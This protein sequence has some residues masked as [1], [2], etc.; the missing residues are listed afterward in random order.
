M[1]RGLTLGGCHLVTVIGIIRGCPSSNIEALAEA[2][3]SAGVRALEVTLDSPEPFKSIRALASA[4]PDI[5]VGA[6]TVRDLDQVES[7]AK[8]GARFIVSPILDP[9]LVAHAVT[10]GMTTIPGAATPSEIWMALRLG[11]VAVKVFPAEELG[12]PS[13]IKAVRGPLGYPP[14][15]P[16]GGVDASN[17]KAYLDA[18]ATA[19]GVGS[20]MFPAEAIE[21]GSAELVHSLA[22]QIMQAIR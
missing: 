22:A 14:L 21:K 7:A 18:G 19:V 6:G 3:A 12:G 11:A 10:L 4:Q 9:E 5:A 15:V 16:T 13:S 2:A 20:A 17:A 8:A 1:Q